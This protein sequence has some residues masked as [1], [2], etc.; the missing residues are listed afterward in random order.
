MDRQTDNR[1]GDSDIYPQNIVSRCIDIKKMFSIIMSNLN[2]GEQEMKSL[3]PYEKST[4][5][6]SL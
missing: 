2:G 5:Q 4:L 3:Q 1:L 6:Q